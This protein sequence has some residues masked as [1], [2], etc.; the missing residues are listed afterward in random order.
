MAFLTPVLS[1][2]LRWFPDAAA[3]LATGSAMALSIY[4]IPFARATTV[5]FVGGWKPFNG[6]PIGIH[7]VLDGLTVLMLLTVNLVAFACAVYSIAYMNHYTD[8]AKF[9]T[10]FLLMVAGLNGVVVSGD[11]FNVFVF[12]EITAIACYALV[13][14][15]VEAEELE[16]SFKYQVLGGVA[17]SLILLGIAMFYWLTGTLNLADGAR[18]LSQKTGNPAVLFVGA[19]LFT[20]FGL[21]GALMPFHAWLPDAH[22]SA[23]A[24]VSAML[25]GVVIKVLGVYAICRVFF[26]VIGMTPIL[27]TTL[28][29]LGAASMVAGGFLA[30]GQWDL[31]RL[32]AYSSIGQIGYIVLGIG[33]GTPLGILGGLFHLV[34]H[35]VFKS[36]L[37]LNAGAVEYA[38]GTRNLKL[39]GGLNRKMPVTSGTSMIASFSIAGL[40]PFNGFWSK[41][42]I[43]IACIQA[44]HPVYAFWAVLGSIL[45]LAAFLKAQRYVFGGELRETWARVREA[46]AFMCAAMVALAILCVAMGALLIPSVKA[47]VLD[48]AVEVLTGGLSYASKALGG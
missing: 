7:M 45:T 5:Y 27:L 10:L 22:P 41:L 33:L 28:M 29:V 17:S 24:P 2:W 13:A 48:P 3:N 19:L 12:F 43:V 21:K 38:T 44:G 42:I 9:V 39:L 36:L 46:P 18:V 26:N 1:R 20:G 23:P 47:A 32:M 15:G 11:L 40:P 4:A 35:T 6:I 16:A 34:N 25:S 31:K 8:K 37:F 30:L 14:F